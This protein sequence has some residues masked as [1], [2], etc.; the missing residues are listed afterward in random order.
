MIGPLSRSSSQT[1]K[2][3]KRPQENIDQRALRLWLTSGINIPEVSQIKGDARYLLSNMI[4]K[5]TLAADVYAISKEALDQFGLREVDLSRTYNRHTFYGKEKP[6]IYEHPVPVRLVRDAILNGDKTP[7][8]VAQLLQEMPPVSV[9]LRSENE[10]LVKAKLTRDMPKEW[11]F[12]DEPYARYR[13]VGIELS[14]RSLK[15]KGEIMP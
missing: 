4:A 6:F 5:Y 11:D 2:V 3:R 1:N 8:N 9:L 13:A 14:D 15:V 10:R 12:G 7:D